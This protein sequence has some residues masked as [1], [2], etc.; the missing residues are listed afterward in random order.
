MRQAV[1]MARM[2]GN[3]LAFM[4]NPIV[5]IM[6]GIIAAVVASVIIFG[7]KTDVLMDFFKGIVP[8]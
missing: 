6:L 3:I 7:V 2:K 5:M 1:R 4:G 8:K